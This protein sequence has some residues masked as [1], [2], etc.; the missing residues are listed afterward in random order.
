MMTSTLLLLLHLIAGVPGARVAVVYRN[1]T[2][3]DS[4]VIAGDSLV[5][6]GD[7]SFHAASTMKV[8]VMIQLFR[9]VDAGRLR[10]DQTVP[11]TNRFTSIADGS[12]F[13]LD[14]KDD[15][16]SSMYETVGTSV[17]VR[18]LLDLMIQRSS[19]V[20]TN[21]LIALLDATRV[22]STAHALGATHMQ[23]LRGVE[24]GVA[25]QRGLNNTVTARDLATLMQAIATDR[26][27]SPASCRAMRD[28][29]FGQEFNTEIPAGL[30]P[31]TRVAH[32]TGQ[33][34]GIL[35]DAA[36]VYPAGRA[37]YVLVVL[38]GNIPDEHVAQHLIAD[39]SRAVYD[40]TGPGAK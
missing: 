38:T 33:I 27:A 21:T 18:H 2:T 26:A 8:A 34:T 5:I 19:N 16:D 10:L 9:D 7:S 35:H 24:D 36:I 6:A 23:V 30:P 4:L 39:I 11:V 22:D 28:V 12:S 13:S 29:L 25:F 15:S 32:K 37:P 31:G 17:P 3:G 1:L 20:A 40:G 14:R